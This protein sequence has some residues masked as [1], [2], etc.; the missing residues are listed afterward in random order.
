M[1]PPCP[2][3]TL[4]CS[5][6][7][8]GPGP[9]SDNKA[10]IETFSRPRF[11]DLYNLCMTRTFLSTQLTQGK[12]VSR[13]GPHIDSFDVWLLIQWTQHRLG[14]RQGGV[15]EASKLSAPRRSATALFLRAVR[16]LF[17]L[18]RTHCAQTV[19]VLSRCSLPHF[20]QDFVY[21]LS[22]R[23]FLPIL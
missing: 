9:R 12:S 23:N 1:R 17:W 8:G 22:R 5:Q 2:M 16:S 6:R 11:L 18:E 19:L 14:R 21:C 13:S 10:S 20:A 4:R 7:N 15:R 3:S